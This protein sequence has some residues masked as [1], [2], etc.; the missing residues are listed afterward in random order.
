MT[1][2][3]PRSGR[4]CIVTDNWILLAP[5]DNW[6][7][8]F[9]HILTKK[10]TWKIRHLSEP[11]EFKFFYDCWSDGIWLHLI[12]QKIAETRLSAFEKDTHFDLDEILVVKTACP[13]CANELPCDNPE[14]AR[15]EAERIFH[16]AI[17]VQHPLK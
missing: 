6:P 5:K 15:L 4:W 7:W 8:Q 9:D 12:H 3:S 16:N 2:V 13:H 11:Y 1:D 10:P 17:V 14:C